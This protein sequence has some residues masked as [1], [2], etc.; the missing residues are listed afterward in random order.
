M[1]TDATDTTGAARVAVIFGDSGC[2]V[3]MDLGHYPGTIPE[4]N[5]R[6][7]RVEETLDVPVTHP[8]VA[9]ITAR[10]EGYGCSWGRPGKLYP[11]DEADIATLRA[12]VRKPPERGPEEPEETHWYTT[13]EHGERELRDDC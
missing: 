12:A 9:A 11:V 6:R 1:T 3:V 2:E 8:A 5:V 7:V 10:G 4:Q 13:N